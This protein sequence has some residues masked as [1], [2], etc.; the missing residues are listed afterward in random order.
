MDSVTIRV[1]AQHRFI[2]EVIC[3]RVVYNNRRNEEMKEWR[4]ERRAGN[5]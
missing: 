5:D 3:P 4:E 1:K 2:Y